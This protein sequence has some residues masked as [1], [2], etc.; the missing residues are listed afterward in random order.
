M[1]S[2]LTIALCSKSAYESYSKTY[3]EIADKDDDESDYSEAYDFLDGRCFTLYYCSRSFEPYG[4]FCNECGFTYKYE[5][6]TNEKLELVS[7]HINKEYDSIKS[8]LK[9]YEKNGVLPG[10]ISSESKQRA[11]NYLDSVVRLLN[12]DEIN[13][14][15]SIIVSTDDNC[16][17][18]EYESY[19]SYLE[20]LEEA[21]LVVNAL[22]VFNSLLDDDS[23]LVYSMD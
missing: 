22:L 20:E 9:Y 10:E 16:S 1:S 4:T 17:Y 2:Y 23:L 15:K 7:S 6:L 13:N 12:E 8:Y 5:P 3:D 21:K 18:G 14:I 19:K 11:L